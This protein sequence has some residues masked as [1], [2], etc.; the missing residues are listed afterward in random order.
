ME[1][2]L[3]EVNTNFT[4]MDREHFYS[5]FM[6]IRKMYNLFRK[7]DTDINA[8]ITA[9]DYVLDNLTDSMFFQEQLRY[10]NLNM[11]DCYIKY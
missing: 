8:K 5:L 9:F 3:L 11:I 10:R 2:G 4:E 7:Y 1:N 6:N